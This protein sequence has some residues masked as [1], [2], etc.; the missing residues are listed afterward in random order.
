MF[1][2]GLAALHG[3]PKELTNTLTDHKRMHIY[4]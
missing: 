4:R 1:H 2:N 3:D